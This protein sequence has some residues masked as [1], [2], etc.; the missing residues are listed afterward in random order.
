MEL[1]HGGEPLETYPLYNSMQA[2]SVLEQ[3]ACAL[4]VGEVSAAFEH[5]DLHW[6][7]ILLEKIEPNSEDGEVKQLTRFYSSSLL[8]LFVCLCLFTFDPWFLQIWK[9]E[10]K[11]NKNESSG[12]NLQ[13]YKSWERN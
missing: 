4:A 2:V 13:Q 11:I 12:L 3:A 10:G 1:S 5:R 7:N 9:A 8:F 6:G